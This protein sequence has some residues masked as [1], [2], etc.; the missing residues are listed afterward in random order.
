MKNGRGEKKNLCGGY[1]ESFDSVRVGAIGPVASAECIWGR[2]RQQL[3]MRTTGMMSS[4]TRELIPA[5]GDKN[6]DLG[7]RAMTVRPAYGP[8]TTREVSC[9]AAAKHWR[10]P[11]F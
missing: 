2:L 4:L 9:L 6:V 10:M 11:A 8:A 5:G 1:V 3:M 7:G